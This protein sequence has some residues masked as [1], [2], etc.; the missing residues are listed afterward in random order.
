MNEKVRLAKLSRMVYNA[1]V[2]NPYRDPA[3]GRYTSGGVKS[4]PKK[5][6][7]KP[8]PRPYKD[9][10]GKW[11]YGIPPHLRAGSTKTETK[12]ADD[13]KPKPRPY[14][15]ANGKWVFGI[16]PHLRE[17]ALKQK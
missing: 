9:A 6:E 17:Q 10:T 4:E 5:T 7:G 8:K 2:G 14:K 12:K 1:T 16:P 15:D 11:V 3:T 13:G